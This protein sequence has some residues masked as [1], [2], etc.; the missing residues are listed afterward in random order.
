MVDVTHMV[1]TGAR[2]LASEV[3]SRS[4]STASSS[5]SHGAAPPCDPFPRRPAE[6]SWSITW[7]M[8]A[9]APIFIITLM[10]ST[11]LTPSVGVP[12]TVMV[13]R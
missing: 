3:S 11:P 8:V 10:T 12:A 13:S 5:C 2:G 6:R 7:L 1:M 4:L 9:M